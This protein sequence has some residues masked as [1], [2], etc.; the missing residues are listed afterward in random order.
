MASL[1]QKLQ[2]FARS[3]QGKKLIAQGRAFATKPENQAKLKSLGSRFTSK[4]TRR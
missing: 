4:D 3:P 2:V 1:I